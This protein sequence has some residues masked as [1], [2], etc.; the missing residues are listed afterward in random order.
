MAT[1]VEIDQV[2][3]YGIPPLPVRRFTVAEYH[4]LIACGVLKSGDPFELLDGW[5]V[6]KMTKNPPHVFAL[7]QLAQFVERNMPPGWHVRRQDP[8][9]TDESEPEPDL[10]LVRGI[11]RDYLY[12]HPG[13]AEIGFL[14]EV[15]HSSLSEDQNIKGPIYAR[16]GIV[17]YWI[18]NLV[19]E[20][21]EVYTDPTGPDPAPRYRQQH[22]YGV[23]DVV[24]LV[25][26]GQTV[27]QLPVRNI[28]P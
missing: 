6:P 7:A 11:P 10:A 18:V 20:Q 23:K 9:T 4:Q 8:I 26:D 17:E 13:P 15:A 22:I 25:I 19:D 1:V 27:A 3:Q 14:A 21:I 24:P 16:A 5:I 12:R 2:P 28:L